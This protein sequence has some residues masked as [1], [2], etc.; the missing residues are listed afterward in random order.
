MDGEIAAEAPA[1]RGRPRAAG[2]DDAIRRASWQVLSETGYDGLTFEAV[3]E[4][5]GCSRPTLYRRYASKG[6]LI[7]DLIT[8]RVAEIEDRLKGS[9][10][11]RQ[12]LIEHLQALVQ[13]LS[14]AGASDLTLGVAQARRRDPRL[15]AAAAELYRENS[16]DY[17]RDLQAASGGQAPIAFYRLLTDTLVGAI[18]FRMA[19]SNAAISD[20][21]IVELADQA[22]RS[23]RAGPGA[24]WPATPAEPT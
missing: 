4:A 12:M 5:A 24:G 6:D 18:M 10:D 15:D 2:L 11:P 9:S 20:A 23:A 3:A 7:L 13:Y 21:E 17:V 8:A 1:R 19:M 14:T 16:M 22:I